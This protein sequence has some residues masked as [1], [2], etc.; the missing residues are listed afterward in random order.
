MRGG[1]HAGV[2]GTVT[3]LHVWGNKSFR[4]E[5]EYDETEYMVIGPVSQISNPPLEVG[6]TLSVEGIMKL[7]RRTRQYHVWSD[8]AEKMV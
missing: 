2:T 5:M 4:V 7:N 3:V 8:T 6:D 1:E